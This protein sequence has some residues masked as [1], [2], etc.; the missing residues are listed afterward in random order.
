MV[1]TTLSPAFGVG[2]ESEIVA[3]ESGK[4]NR[5]AARERAILMARFYGVKSNSVETSR[6]F[7]LVF[8][9]G[10]D[11]VNTLKDVA[12]SHDVRGG[13]FTALGAFQSAAVAY[14]NPSTKEYE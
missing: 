12:Q 14:W 7:L 9:K 4:V 10:D 1:T 8:D 11:F 5:K 6:T 3:A 13:F 2:G